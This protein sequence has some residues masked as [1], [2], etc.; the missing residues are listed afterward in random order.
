KQVNPRLDTGTPAP[1][2]DEGFAWG[3]NEGAGYAQDSFVDAEP[4]SHQPGDAFSFAPP[5]TDWKSY[6]TGKLDDTAEAAFDGF[7][8]QDL[9]A[10]PTPKLSAPSSPELPRAS[11]SQSFGFSFADIVS[12]ED[13]LDSPA[14]E[15]LPLPSEHFFHESASLQPEPAFNDSF[16]SG[17]AL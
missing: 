16:D 4:A 12:D 15:A 5:Q 17:A 2:L 10:P 6:E 9:S 13:E 7:S 11:D 3:L 8:H 1:A 14:P